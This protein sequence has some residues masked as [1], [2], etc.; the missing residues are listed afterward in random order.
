MSVALAA[1]VAPPADPPGVAEAE[2]V[3]SVRGLHVRFPRDGATVH[4]LRGVDLSIAPGEIVA[5]VGESGSGK[6][7]LGLALLGLLPAQARVEGEVRAAGLDIV[8]AT[9]ARRREVRRSSLGA[10][11][12]DPLSSLN[13]SMRVGRQVEEV[14]GSVAEAT[15]LLEAAGIPDPG[16]RMSQYPHELSGGLRQRVM[17]AM[18]VA[19]SPRL[20][21]ADEPTTA[22]DVTVQ[23]QVLDLLRRLRDDVGCSILLITHDLGVGATVAD[24]ICVLYAGRLMESGPAASVARRPSHPY[25]AALL[26]AR[27]TLRSPREVELPTLAGEPP[28]PRTPPPGCAFMPRCPVAFDA[29]GVGDPPAPQPAEGSTESACLHPAGAVASTRRADHARLPVASTGIGGVRVE[30]VV[31]TFGARHR[32]LGRDVAGFDALRGVTLDVAPGEAVAVVGESGSGKTTLLR[33]V[34]GLQA[35]TSGRVVLGEDAR[36]QMVFQDPGSSLTPWLRVG[37][38]VGERVR[39]LDAADREARVA[40][41]LALVGLPADVAR[42]R[43]VQLSGGQRQRVAIARAVIEPTGLLLCDEPISALDASL[44][45]GVLN[46]LARLRRRMGSALVFVTHDLAAARLVADR[47]VVMRDGQVVEEADAAHLVGHAQDRYTQELIA[48]VPEV[49]A[50]R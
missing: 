10:V 39:H 33:V 11:F 25:T 35:P 34:A 13:P 20:L 1:V 22:L 17:I 5:L 18:A 19:G 14:A 12:Q 47:V 42:A 23:A 50:W 41:T 48:A 6:S 4:A 43:P 29:C 38:L 26:S 3:A 36:P 9:E 16:R 27:L 28:D 7:V 37:E 31:V 40:Q 24:R 46:L 2:A 49:A 15:R 30:D 44:S 21:V 8:R 32:L 45:A